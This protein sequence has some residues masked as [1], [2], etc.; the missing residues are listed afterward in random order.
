ERARERLSRQSASR[1]GPRARGHRGRPG[2]AGVRSDR[3]GTRPTRRRRSR[4][5]PSRSRPRRAGPRS[6]D[7]RRLPAARPADLFHRG[8]EG[9]ARLA[10]RD[11]RD[12][13]AGRGRD[14]HRFRARFHSRRNRLLRGLHRLRRRGR[15]ARS[16]PAAQ[17][18]QG[19]R[20]PG[21]RRPAFPVQRLASPGDSFDARAATGVSGI[22]RPAASKPSAKIVSL[23]AL[24]TRRLAVLLSVSGSVAGAPTTAVAVLLIGPVV[25]DAIVPVAWKTAWPPAGSAIDCAIMP[26]PCAGHV[27]PPLAVQVHST[28][29]NAAG[30]VSTIVVLRALAGPALAIEIV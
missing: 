16:G 10:D 22:S 4:R 6:R 13:T 15:R 12:R 2:G 3:G 17:G 7:P 28:S 23:P 5:V 24:S 30:N 27:A 14:P 1:R 9:S 19:L 21:W 11:R 25:P 8:G 18:R 26:L 20:R 29:F